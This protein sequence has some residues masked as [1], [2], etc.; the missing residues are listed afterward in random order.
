MSEARYFDEDVIDAGAVDAAVRDMA[1]RQFT[2][3]LV[4][5]F[6]LLAAASL[7]AIWGAHSGP[8]EASTPHRIVKIEAQRTLIAEPVLESAPRG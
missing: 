3:S 1:R 2:A 6:A 7:M 4:V 5:A 8:V